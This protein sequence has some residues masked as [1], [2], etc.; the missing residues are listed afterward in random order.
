MDEDIKKQVPVVMIDTSNVPISTSSED[1]NR[2]DQGSRGSDQNSCVDSLV[3]YDCFTQCDTSTQYLSRNSWDMSTATSCIARKALYSY[4]FREMALRTLAIRGSGRKGPFA[5]T[6]EQLEVLVDPRNVEIL[7]IIGG[8]EGLCL[9]LH[10][11]PILGLN[12]DEKC[13]AKEVTLKDLMSTDDYL[14]YEKMCQDYK[15]ECQ[16]LKSKDNVKKKCMFWKKKKMEFSPSNSLFMKKKFSEKTNCMKLYFKKFFHCINMIYNAILRILCF[17]P[18]LML[19]IKFI[20]VLK[21]VFI[22]KSES[23][24]EFLSLYGESFKTR[25]S[26]FGINRTPKRHIKG[27]IPLIFNVFKDSILILLLCSTIVSFGIDIYFGLVHSNDDESY[28]SNVDGIAMLVAIAVIS[29]VSAVNDYQKEVQFEQLNAKKENHDV[30]VIRSGK[31]IFIS[32]YDLQVGDILLFELGDLL[33]ADG[34]LIDSYNL[35]CDESSTTG[36]SD[37]IEKVSCS[38]CL[39]NTSP[40]VIFDEKYDPFM[41]S[42]SKVVEGT[43]KYIVTSVG[44]HS[45]YEKIMVSIQTELDSTPLQIKLSKLAIGISKFGICVSFSLFVILFCRFLVYLVDN[46]ITI[47]EKATNFMKILIVSITI[48]VVALPEGLPLAITLALAFAT[49][50]MSKENNLVRHL[51]SCET[52]GNVTTICSDKTGTLTQNKMTLVVGIIGL[53][54]QFRDNFDSEIDENTSEMVTLEASSLLKSLN[55]SVTQLIIQSIVVSSTAFLATDKQGKTS[56]L[57]SKTDCALLE[58]AQ[59]YFNMDDPSIERAKVDVLQFIPF[60]SSRKYMASIISLP[61][62]GARLYVKGASETLLE[63]SSYVLHEPLSRKSDTL[64]VLPLT[65]EGKDLIYKTIVRYATHSLRTIALVYKDFDVWPDHNL[66]NSIT[67][68]EINFNSIF[69]QMIFIGVLG[70]MDLLREGVKDAIET[71]KKAGITVRMVTGDNKITASAIARLCG[72]YTPGGILMEGVDFRN[73]SSE[74]MDMIVPKL[75]V[76]ARS[77][78]EDKKILVTKLKELG[79]IVAVTGDG[80]ND[81]PALKKADVGFSMG[82]SGTDVAK[83]ASD[84]IL[85]DDNFSSIVKACAWG[86]TINLAI[87]KFLQFQITVNITAVFLVFVTAI[88]DSEMRSVL[89]PVQLLWVNLIM[90]TFA[91]L[92]LATDP[93]NSTILNRKPEPKT[94]LITFEMWK[95]I[96]AQSIYQLLVMLSL[97]FWG[98][99]IFRYNNERAYM[100][101]TLPTLIFNVFVF[102]QIFNEL[103]CWRLGNDVNIFEGIRSNPWYIFINLIMISGQVIIVFYGGKAF[104]VSP[105][106]LEQ[107]GI[108]IFLGALSVLVFILVRHIP[109]RFL[110]KIIP[111]SFKQ[112]LLKSDNSFSNSQTQWDLASLQVKDELVFL[113]ALKNRYTVDYSRRT[114]EM[115][116][117][118][119]KLTQAIHITGEDTEKVK[120]LLSKQNFQFFV[121]PSLRAATLAPAIMAG[122]IGGCISSG[123]PQTAVFNDSLRDRGVELYSFAQSDKT[124]NTFDQNFEK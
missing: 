93:P 61:N 74:D 123:L 112:S 57:G 67:G 46:K 122:S 3:Q 117:F 115:N 21:E 83:E 18:K 87:K 76:L 90:D 109:D 17:I 34:I 36:E 44:L 42:G 105:L 82:I 7:R 45:Y 95:M 124:T 96:I 55:P 25:I 68:S 97:R 52:M 86:R 47:Y 37:A 38:V 60:S 108:S 70:I 6:A 114:Q 23:Y 27:I 40:D 66:Q 50:K 107:W 69:S 65:Q 20:R 84:I 31:P 81:G 33:P 58:F 64:S 48:L 43:G 94:S 100:F 102:M 19:K 14:M 78:P 103:N 28:N 79:E 15:I 113:K 1:Q 120:D 51:R 2:N 111:L 92:A 35:C 121:T 101:D 63:Y 98:G 118:Y 4:A 49:R 119:E 56:F 80:T 29:V 88:T 73:L 54:T 71:C 99:T 26:V 59:K 110:M 22:G 30:R 89:T 62:G 41:I 9:G 24:K 5:F 116:R 53:S 12:V 8:I 77:T 32:V 104:Q 16:N 91:A 106:N 72:I 11:D 39:E 85:M 75:Q 13:V 10:T